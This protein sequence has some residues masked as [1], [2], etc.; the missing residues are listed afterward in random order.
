M[1]MGYHRQGREVGEACRGEACILRVDQQLTAG[2]TVRWVRVYAARARS[3]E[4][5]CEDFAHA[6]VKSAIAPLA[7]SDGQVRCRSPTRSL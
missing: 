6:M 1:E 4:V 5:F 2:S 7:G 3:E